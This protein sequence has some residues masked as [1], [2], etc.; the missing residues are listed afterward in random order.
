MGHQ[1]YPMISMFT[2]KVS[3]GTEISRCARLFS[4]LLVPKD[5]LSRSGSLVAM[6]MRVTRLAIPVLAQLLKISSLMKVPARLDSLLPTN[7]GEHPHE[8]D[9]LFKTGPKHFMLN[10]QQ[11]FEFG[12]QRS[13]HDVINCVC[14]C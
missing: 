4:S 7:N 5:R 2:R 1:W 8:F 9:L 3:G 6:H 14:D 10:F 12:V 13:T 11:F